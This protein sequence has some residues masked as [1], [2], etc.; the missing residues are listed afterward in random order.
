MYAILLL[1]MILYPIS[2]YLYTCYF[3]RYHVT[4]ILVTLPGTCYTVCS[5]ILRMFCIA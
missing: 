3:T 4:C 1:F 5:G 2:C